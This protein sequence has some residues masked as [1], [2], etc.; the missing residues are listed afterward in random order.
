MAA[1]FRRESWDAAAF[2]P[3]KHAGHSGGLAAIGRGLLPQDLKG[4]AWIE[5][6]LI[7][8]EGMGVDGDEVEAA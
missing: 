8:Q 1:S 4:D 6:K 3:D 2:E 7:Q 5:I